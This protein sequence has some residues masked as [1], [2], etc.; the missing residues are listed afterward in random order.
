MSRS[1][2]KLPSPLAI[3]RFVGDQRDFAVA[4]TAGGGGSGGEPGNGV[5]EEVKIRWGVWVQSLGGEVM[6][7]R[8]GD[9]YLLQQVSMRLRCTW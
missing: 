1:K 3:C 7:T 4:V 6:C 8:L 9:V 5:V 2:F